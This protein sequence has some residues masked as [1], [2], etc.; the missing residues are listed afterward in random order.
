MMADG[1]RGHA[2]VSSNNI[3]AEFANADG[4]H[5]ATSG[6]GDGAMNPETGQIWYGGP[7]AMIEITAVPVLYSGGSAASVGI[8]AFCG[9][10]AATDAEAPFVFT[11]TCEGTS[12]ADG[13]NPEFTITAADVETLNGDDIF[14]L[15][16]D[17]EGPSAP[18][19]SPNPN[20]REA[21]WV[22]LAV[23]FTG[24]QKSS[25]KNGWLTYN[26]DDDAGV[27]G[28]NPLLRYAAVPSSG[29]VGLDEALAAPILTLANLPSPSGDKAN[30]YCAV[31]SAVDLLGNESDL[32]EAEEDDGDCV[33]AGVPTIE[34]DLN[35]NPQI[36]SQ[37][38]DGYMK[39]L[40]DAMATDA[41]DEATE[42]LANAGLWVGVDI[43]PPAVAFTG[44]SPEDQAIALGTNGWTVHVTD[45]G[46][47]LATDP[48][49]ASVEVRNGDG[50]DELKAGD[51]ANTFTA[52]TGTGPRFTTEVNATRDAG[53]YTFAATASDM[54][55]NESA[56]VS[57]MA[58][59][60]GA[61]PTPIRLFA[62]PGADDFTHDKTLLATDN[63]SIAGYYVTAP[64]AV[65]DLTLPEI[66][67][68]STTLDAY[69]AS[70]LTD[71]LLVRG[72][73][74][75]PFLAVQNGT[76][77]TGIDVIKA[78]VSDQAVTATSGDAVADVTP[79]R[80]DIPEVKNILRS[81][82]A[83]TVTATNDADETAVSK[84]DS[85]VKLSATAQLPDES[86]DF[87]FSRVDFY[88]EVSVDLD[89]DPD[90]SND[91]VTE[92]WFIE[93]VSGLSATVKTVDDPDGR[94]WTYETE[95]DAEA[96]LAAIGED[97]YGGMIVGFGVSTEKD[98]SVAVADASPDVT[99]VKR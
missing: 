93:S 87:P 64:V 16:L 58:L 86:T 36:Q 55:G 18:T 57:R 60:D 73:V 97:T 24:E 41:T 72:P 80:G 54:A 63:L 51:E 92:L 53:Y 10:S 68:E 91:I 90:T 94:D 46:S 13:E 23:D 85:T 74:E 79:D 48:I 20:G 50:T 4:V 83:F 6:L 5:V 40:E 12:D 19:F 11:P 2:T 82:G 78:Y 39:L 71:D 28:Y 56:S 88:A 44:A 29:G 47:G 3:P 95:V 45:A 30:A 52:P 98:G 66:R 65:N 75:L 76:M 32:P 84:D 81:D 38:A 99:V 9:A 21:G 49:D 67:L 14:P 96:F 1:T 34:A 8:G 69:D 43:T 59:H 35:A 27:G 89:N 17:Y 7:S 15:Y 33:M 77:V 70:S 61:G 62:V 25:N 31:V 42:A 26:N 22:N 37:T